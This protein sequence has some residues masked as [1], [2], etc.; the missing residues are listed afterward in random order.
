M[1][2]KALDAEFAATQNRILDFYNAKIQPIDDPPMED[3]E[4]FRSLNEGLKTLGEKRQKAHEM[5]R[6]YQQAKAS[7]DELARPVNRP[8]FGGNGDGTGA[9][10][11]TQKSMGERVIDMLYHDGRWLKDQEMQLPEVRSRDLKAP[12]YKDAEFKTTM[13]TS[14]GLAPQ[15]IRSGRIEYALVRPIMFT[16]I[17][18]TIDVSSTASYTYVR[19][20]TFT[21]SAGAVAEAGPYPESALAYTVITVYPTK[22]G[23][24]LPVTKE[25]LT[26]IPGMQ[27]NI[28]NRLSLM[29]SL[30]QENELLN[31]NGSANTI[32]GFLNQVTQTYTIS[33]SDTNFDAIARAMNL[34]RTVGFAQPDAI[35]LHPNNFMTMR[36]ARTADGIYIMGNPDQ[37]GLTQIFGIRPVQSLA[38]PSGTGLVGDFSS[39]CALLSVWGLAVEATNS[40]GTTFRNDIITIKASVRCGL[41]IQRLQAFC[42]VAALT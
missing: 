38:M 26:D 32:N 33:G 16:D 31:G 20:T 9:E 36:L 40:D 2:T 7:A 14:A 1:E 37:I 28:N 30:E 10:L 35:V 23:T 41:V 25:Q 4:A 15:I 5:E 29:V 8:N 13:T 34:C 17:L 3:I 18:P 21:N 6:A 11:P 22:I 27:Q 24:V 19:E 42:K 12:A 39:Y